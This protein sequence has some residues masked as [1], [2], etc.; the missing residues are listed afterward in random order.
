MTDK[1]DSDLA[2]GLER[3][4]K[5]PSRQEA[6]LLDRQL[7][8]RQSRQDHQG[9]SIH[10]P[11]SN[12]KHSGKDQPDAAQREQLNGRA[13]LPALSEDESQGGSIQQ[14]SGATRQQ[15][16]RDGIKEADRDLSQPQH[17]L[18]EDESEEK[19]P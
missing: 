3:K 11:E 7:R 12:A 19:T 8:P 13:T 5:S 4:V 6:Y 16:D 2:K 15:P 17:D 14:R 18:T 1:Q 10:P 9:K